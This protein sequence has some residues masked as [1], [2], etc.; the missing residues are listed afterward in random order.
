MAE[1]VTLDVA[2][3]RREYLLHVPADDPRAPR[4]A[5]LLLHGTGGSA[6]WAEEEAGF[7]AF[8]DR[9]G[10]VAVIPQGLPPDP[11]L[12]PKF[13]A[14]PPAW[15]A[16]GTLFP[17]H[18]PDDLAYFRLLLDDLPA[19][20][21]IDPARI[22]VTGF[23]N[24]A[25]MAFELAAAIGDRIAAIAPVAGYCRV[26]HS[27]RAVPTLFM[28]GADD[29]IVPPDGGKFRSPWTGELKGRP[30]VW[31]SL[32][33]WAQ[34][35]GCDTRHCVECES[36]GVRI[37]RFAGPVDFL[38]VTIADLGHHWPGGLGRLK[39]KLAGKA[40]N[41]VDANVVIWQFFQRHALMR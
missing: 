4:P 34:A 8:A 6:K 32:C 36:E 37:E 12:P 28:I 9:A 5:V 35:I 13:I 3:V 14:N 17:G 25:A 29:P 39:S 27:V 18:E 11:D 38:V 30:P 40:S 2:G 23:S 19:R 21:A 1:M 26:N 22:Y 33:R 16:G 10:F 24:G 31:E 7:A 41:R 15:N 20:A